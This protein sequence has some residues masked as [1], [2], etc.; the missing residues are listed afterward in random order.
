MENFITCDLFGGADLLELILGLGPVVQLLLG[1]TGVLDQDIKDLRVHLRQQR[2]EGVSNSW[3]PESYSA[4]VKVPP[5]S[6][7][8]RHQGFPPYAS[9]Y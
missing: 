8:D 1:A 6:C 4:S 5:Q 3:R 7:L 2:T 9:E